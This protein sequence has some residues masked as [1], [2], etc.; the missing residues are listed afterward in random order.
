MK[1][2][3]IRDWNR[4]FENNRSRELK[5]LDFVLIPNRHDGESFSEIMQQKDGAKI[6]AGWVLI[7]QVASKCDPRGTLLRDSGTPLRPGARPHNSTSLSLKTRAPKEWFDLAFS[8]L[9]ENTDWLEIEE[10]TENPAPACELSAPACGKVTLKGREQNG[11][12]EKG[13]L[14]SSKPSN[15]DLMT[16]ARILIHYLNEKTGRHYRETSANL[17]VISARLKEDGVELDGVKQMIDRQCDRWNGTEQAEY[18]RPETLFGK[19]KFDSYYAAKDVPI[20][21]G[22][23]HV[24]GKPK[25]ISYIDS[26]LAAIEKDL[27]L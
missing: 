20:T 26:E 5:K 21:V 13:N 24:N 14:L 7:L 19:S 23:P 15:V 27:N 6:F 16:K 12:E 18:L 11:M 9:E 10:I 17:T 3:K 1:L 25:S 22:Q 8:F 2:Y 4:L